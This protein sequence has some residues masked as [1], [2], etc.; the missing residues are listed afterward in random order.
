VLPAEATATGSSLVSG[1]ASGVLAGHATGVDEIEFLCPN[2]HL[3]HGQA[4]MQGRPGICPECQSKFRIPTY[5]NWEA[6]AEQ[7]PAEAPRQPTFGASAGVRVSAPF[8]PMPDSA[9]PLGQ[10]GLPTALHFGGV[11]GAG[12]AHPLAALFPRLW[13]YKSIGATM[14][15]QYGDGNQLVPDRFASAL[16]Q[17]SHGVFAVDDTNGTFTITAVEWGAVSAIVLRN[18]KKLIDEMTR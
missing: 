14:E 18:V 9:V 8:F 16:S 4:A 1:L 12:T 10:E 15:I 6:A 11:A 2:N 3:L 7:S 13:A 5:D 17:G